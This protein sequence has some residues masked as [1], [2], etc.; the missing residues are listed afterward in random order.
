MILHQREKSFLVAHHNRRNKRL[1]D[2]EG[3]SVYHVSG[4]RQHLNTDRT[5]H[6]PSHFGITVS[7]IRSDMELIEST[8]AHATNLT[9]GETNSGKSDCLTP[10]APTPSSLSLDP[11]LD[12]H[13][14]TNGHNSASHSA[15]SNSWPGLT[16]GSPPPLAPSIDEHTHTNGNSDPSNVS[17]VVQKP[18]TSNFPVHSSSQ[19]SKNDIQ[20]KNSHDLSVDGNEPLSR[21]TRSRNKRQPDSLSKEPAKRLRTSPS[22]SSATSGA[23]LGANGRTNDVEM[24]DPN[25]VSPDNPT[26]ITTS[27][28]S[29]QPMFSIAASQSPA[30]DTDCPT[31]GLEAKSSSLQT[32]TTNADSNLDPALVAASRPSSTPTE[33]TSHQDSEQTPAGNGQST[34]A[35]P[36]TSAGSSKLEPVPSSLANNPYLGLST[37]FLKGSTGPNGSSFNPYAFYYGPGTPITPHTPAYPYPFIYHLPSPIAAP[38]MYPASPNFPSSPTARKSSPAPPPSNGEPQRQKP[39]RLKAHTVTSGNHNI[40][41]VPRDKEGKPML[42]LNV[43]IMTVIRLG[44]VCMREHFHTERYIFPVGYEV[45]RS[46]PSLL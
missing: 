15:Q 40:P 6:C 21:R 14:S 35:S 26:S 46:D 31:S 32:S 10:Q 13:G 20:D 16:G 3:L 8:T 25:I 43:G 27:D 5:F 42:P 29:I 22:G 36:S 18:L 12:A 23:N 4:A 38:T 39:K 41:I 33:P 17:P 34:L 24:R 37:A 45:T 7:P 11:E 1:A 19:P 2:K 30:L 9:N 28:P 44:E